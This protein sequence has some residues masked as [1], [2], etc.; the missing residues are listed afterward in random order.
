VF[1]SVSKGVL[2]RKST[3]SYAGPHGFEVRRVVRTKHRVNG[4][5]K[6]QTEL[7]L[8]LPPGKSSAVTRIASRIGEDR[9]EVIEVPAAVES[10]LLALLPERQQLR[11]GEPAVGARTGAEG[12]KVESSLATAGLNVRPAEKE[13]QGGVER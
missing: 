2:T 6:Y 9:D 4:M 11:P 12:Q 5:P 8:H 10:E 3:V 1:V 13:I 7:G